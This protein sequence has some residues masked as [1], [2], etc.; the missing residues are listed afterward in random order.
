L[1][2][3]GRYKVTGLV[4]LLGLLT[5]LRAI[6]P[7]LSGYIEISVLAAVVL[8]SGYVEWSRNAPVLRL[9]SRR[10]ILFDQACKRAM[11]RLREHDDTARL[12]IMQIDGLPFRRTRF[13]RIIYHLHV[14]KEDPDRGMRMKLWQ[15]VAGQA[16]L[17]GEFCFGDI[18]DKEKGP[19]FNLDAEQQRKTQDVRLVLSMPILK[20]V[21]SDTD[22]PETSGKVIGVVN[23]DSKRKDALHFYRTLII[24]NEPLMHHQEQALKE[25]SEYCSFVMS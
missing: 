23:I 1:R 16:A 8:I 24:D 9:Q 25:I 13:L 7:N 5:Q 6:W 18:A 17:S 14:S 15:G 4:A 22:E 19:R 11:T 3:L 20:A 21:Q 10:R 12:N 2:R